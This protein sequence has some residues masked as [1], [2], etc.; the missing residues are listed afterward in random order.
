MYSPM[1]LTHY[2]ASWTGVGKYTGPVKY[3]GVTVEKEDVKSLDAGLAN[4]LSPG[5]V[6]NRDSFVEIIQKPLRMAKKYNLPLYCGEW[7]C[8]KT[9]D[10]ASRV[11]WYADVKSV[12]EEHGIAWTT[13]DYKGGFGLRNSDGSEDR[14]VIDVLFGKK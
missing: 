13:W 9:V 2:K 12:F 3:P 10:Q 4:S 11:R 14:D 7:G 8:L 1:P 6:Y 5:K